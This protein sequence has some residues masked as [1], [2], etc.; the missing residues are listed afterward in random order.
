M[1]VKEY[2]VFSS[3]SDDEFESMPNF[4]SACQLANEMIK[5]NLNDEVFV[6]IRYLN[7]EEHL[8]A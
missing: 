3:S 7:V 6:V 8:Y 1:I 4:Q 2:G 5:S